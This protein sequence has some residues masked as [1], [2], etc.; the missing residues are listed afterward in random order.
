MCFGQTYCPLHHLQFPPLSS[1]HTMVPSQF[2][3]QLIYF[4]LNFVKGEWQ[5]SCLIFLKGAILLDQR[6]L[7]KTLV[8]LQCVFLILF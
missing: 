7:L 2:Y 8:F 3:V 5:D 6:C 4:E 1:H